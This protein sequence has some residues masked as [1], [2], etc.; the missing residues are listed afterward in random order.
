[1]SYDLYAIGHLLP[2]L[3]KK[4]L[5]SRIYYVD[6]HTYTATLRRMINLL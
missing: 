5:P 6:S 3:I 4:K 2:L 1:M